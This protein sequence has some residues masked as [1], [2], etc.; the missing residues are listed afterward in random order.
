MV[1]VDTE[2]YSALARSKMFKPD[3]LIVDVN[4]PGMTGIEFARAIRKEPWLRHGNRASQER[5][6]CSLP[7]LRVLRRAFFT[8]SPATTVRS[9]AG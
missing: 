7:G 9:I 4:M 6:N 3:L 8:E 1:E 5:R 2:P